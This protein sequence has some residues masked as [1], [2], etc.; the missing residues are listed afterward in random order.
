MSA[1][2]AFLIDVRGF[3][4][5][6]TFARSASKARYAAFRA[7]EDAGYRASFCSIEARRAHEWDDVAPLTLSGVCYT[8]EG[9]RALRA[10]RLALLRRDE[11]A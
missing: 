7:A 2:R 9:V 4:P 5:C 1:V 11:S 6:Y 10:R 3:E 8:D